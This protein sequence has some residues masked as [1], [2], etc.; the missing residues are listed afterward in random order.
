LRESCPIGKVFQR[1]GTA[2][3][4]CH[5]TED[6]TEG[7]CSGGGKREEREEGKLL[8]GAIVDASR[9]AIWSIARMATVPEG[10]VPEKSGG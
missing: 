6:A 5:T 3:R 9:W 2:G 4:G 7:A 10:M 1:A 8:T